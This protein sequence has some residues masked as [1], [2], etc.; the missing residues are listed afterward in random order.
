[1]FPMAIAALFMFSAVFSAVYNNKTAS[2]SVKED[3]A[4]ITLLGVA[5]IG[6]IFS[7]EV[8]PHISSFATLFDCFGLFAGIMLGL[9]SGRWVA[10]VKQW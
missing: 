10:H 6:V 7:I 3:V 4:L 2:E 1:M 8:L 9:L 5:I